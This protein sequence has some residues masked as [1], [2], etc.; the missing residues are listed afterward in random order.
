MVASETPNVLIVDDDEINLNLLVAILKGLDVHFILANSGYE[1]L[2]R[3]E[4]K[5]I[6]LALLDIR[7]EGMDGI[8]LANIIQND[9]KRDKVPILFI[10]AH[11]HDEV[12][13]VEVYKSGAVDFIQKPFLPKIVLSKVKVFLELYRQKLEIRKQ[14]QHLERVVNELEQSN[15]TLQE[16]EALLNNIIDNLPLMLFI[17]EAKNLSLVRINKAGEELLGWTREE[18][19]GKTDF[20]FFP[21]RQARSFVAD[22]KKVITNKML[23]DVPDEPIHTKHK[24]K[25]IL[26]TI[27][28]PILNNEG[29]AVFLLGISEDITE[30]R[31]Y[32]N[33]LKES[34]K[35]YRA[36]LN[37]SPSGI[38]IMN[39][40]GQITEIS[41]II[42]EIFGIE[43]KAEFIGAY[44]HHLFPAKE[45]KKIRSILSKTRKEG[46]VQNIEYVLTRKNKTRYICEISTTL[47]QDAQGHAKGFMGIVRDISQRKKIE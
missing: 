26:H 4:G 11:F 16:S 41:D 27:K 1:A 18:L 24:G 14:K 42:L 45:E 28:I 23:V 17:K 37:A 22:D 25:R 38:V 15:S 3:I 36:M 12:E 9:Q 7:M 34:E 2:E 35:M 31:E 46:L 10:S 32:E 6:A 47:I 13:L 30:K 20:D 19:T 39:S 44:F 8:T 21:A 29:E 33:T 43:N 40:K 5:E